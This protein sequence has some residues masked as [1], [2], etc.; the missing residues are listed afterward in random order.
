MNCARCKTELSNALVTHVLVD[1]PPAEP[2]IEGVLCGLCVSALLL[3]MGGRRTL[4]EHK[5]S[6][7]VR[8]EDVPPG[9]HC[10]TCGLEKAAA[11]AYHCEACRV[12]GLLVLKSRCQ[13]HPV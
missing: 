3:F 5:W 2:I 10:V 1:V 12:E 9:A 6:D 4:C 11:S 7:E 13:R 8:W